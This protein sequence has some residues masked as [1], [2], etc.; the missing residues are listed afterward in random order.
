[1]AGLKSSS[2]GIDIAKT[3]PQAAYAAFVA[4]FRHRLTYFIRTIPNMRPILHELDQVITIELIPGRWS[5]ICR[6]ARVIVAAS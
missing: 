3:K 2:F 6:G 4:G 5:C 1:M